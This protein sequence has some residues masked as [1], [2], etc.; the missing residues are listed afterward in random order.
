MKL[1]TSGQNYVNNSTN[2]ASILLEKEGIQYIAYWNGLT[3]FA[4]VEDGNGNTVERLQTE[5][6]H[7]PE[8]GDWCP[9]FMVR[10]FVANG[11]SI[12]G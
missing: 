8:E 10:D 3:N 9:N 12:V 5:V 1:S 4:T 2:S 6:E 11:Y 7:D